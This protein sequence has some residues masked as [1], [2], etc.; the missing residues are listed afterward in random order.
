MINFTIGPVQMDAETLEIGQHQ[1]PYFRTAEFSALMKE[2]E[3]MLCRLFDAPCDS[4]VVFMTGSGTASMEGG[5]MNCF[6]ND[7]RVLVVN[8]GSFGH[9][10]VELCEIHEIPFTEIKLEYGTPLTAEILQQFDGKQYTGMMLQLC[11]T[12]TGVLYDMN[13]VGEF[14]KRN[15]IF[16]F[17]D[18]VSGF[19]ADEFSMKKMNVNAAITGSQKALSL[20]PSMSFTVLDSVA[21]QRCLK[22]RVK[23]MYFNYSDYLRNGERG[24]TPFTP[25][26]AT[27][28]MLNEKLKRIERVG[29]ISAMNKMAKERA[30]YFRGKIKHLPFKSFTAEGCTSNCVT[31]LMPTTAGVNA[32]RIFEIIKDEYEIW[33]CPNGGDMAEKVF[34]VGHIGNI[35]NDEIDR[36][37]EVFDDL[38]KR[39]LL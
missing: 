23:S 24:Q 35:T 20:P 12:S 2:N 36:L 22:N 11:E 33:V 37:V 26:V 32:H 39:K 19:L 29:G 7:D 17:V 21:Q 27:L 15:N 28:I 8:G 4:K 30:D 6:T 14:C 1:I 16:L 3:Q 31:A 9:R 5:V 34:R 10:F 13:L 38:V 25:A 18:A